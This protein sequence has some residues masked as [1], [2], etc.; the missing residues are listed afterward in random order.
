MNGLLGPAQSYGGLLSEEDR[1]AIQQQ[2]LL[3]LGAGMLANSG[4]SPQRTTTGQAIGQG[5]MAAQGAGQQAQQDM[6]SAMLL[7]TK[8]ANAG[9]QNSPSDVRSYEYAKTNGYKGTFEDW[10]KIAAAQPTRPADLQVFD[11]F[12]KMTPEQQQQYMKLQRQPTVPQVVMIGNVPHLVDK[13]SNT[14]T[15]LSTIDKE[16][17]GAATVAGAEAQATAR[18]K[19]VGEAEGGIE[20]K[21]AAAQNVNDILDIAD[22]LIDLSTGSKIGAGADKVAAMF[23]KSLDGAQAAAQLQILQAALMFAQPRMEGPQGVLDVQLYE[24]AA[25]QIGDPTVP[26][27]TKKAA[28]KT[29]RALQSKYKEQSQR[30]DAPPAAPGAA[31]RVRVDAE[32]N[33]IGN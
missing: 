24:K 10:K 2:Q 31:K 26:A 32:G 17:G 28:V 27:A 20:K 3:A 7:K 23:G 6:L 15:P 25:G 21:A 13:I 9:K 16:A 1:R 5:L 22:P 30:L 12:Q 33:V 8:L 4:Y 19:V 11:E 29:I 14:V 18:G